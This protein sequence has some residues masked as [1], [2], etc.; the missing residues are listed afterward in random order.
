MFLVF[1]LNDPFSL[2]AY[3]NIPIS[4][5]DDSRYCRLIIPNDM[6]EKCRYFFKDSL[7]MPGNYCL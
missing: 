1:V 3:L 2:R 6:L 7:H 5:I 4:M